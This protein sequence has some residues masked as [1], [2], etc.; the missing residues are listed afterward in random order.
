M[1]SS[2]KALIGSLML[3][4]GKFLEVS[5]IVKATDFSEDDARRAYTIAL[6]L[7][8]N[9]KQVDIVTV[10]AED[11]SLASYLAS[12]T[13]ESSPLGT[14]DFAR[15]VAN[16]AK[17]N[18]IKCRLTEIATAKNTISEKLEDILGLYRSEIEVG[19]KDPAVRAVINR[20]EGIVAEN[21]KR[22]S[23]GMST[24]FDF[25]DDIFVQYVIGHLWTIGAYTS[26]GKTAMMIQ[27]LCNLLKVNNT[28]P[29]VV[30][31]TEM[32]EEQMMSRIIANFTGIHSQRIL[33]GKYWQGEEEEVKRC[34]AL[35]KEKPLFLYDDL[36]SLGDIEM[37][38]RKVDLQ[39][40]VD[41]GF[42]DYVQNCRVPGA[43]SQYQ[44]QATMAK[45]LQKLAKDVRCALICLSQV[46][47]D[48]GRGNTDQLELKGAGEWAA[49]S[50][51]GIMLYRN[52]TDKYALKF[53]VKKNRHGALHTHM[54]EYK[55][56]FT[57]L[58][59][60]GPVN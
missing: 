20:L 26:V 2:E 52:K 16:T 21:R 37:A 28:P 17:E 22:G 55:M 1:I 18:R 33:A 32:T 9:R 11:M 59:A 58:E 34:K 42:I 7:W 40:G 25:L 56:D 53:A 49:V 44:E 45:R 60:I 13:S 6:N 15:T 36:Y 23:T 8:R 47:N 46:S 19:R 31:S 35:I 50:D 14:I 12:A 43:S 24:G 48:V 38:F 39:G 5:E 4:P 29:I 10:A 41:I 3:S 51:I 30:I 54:L 27:L 57:R